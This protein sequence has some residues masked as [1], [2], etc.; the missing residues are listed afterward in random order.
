VKPFTSLKEAKGLSNIRIWM[1]EYQ[2]VLLHG[3]GA[4]T[5]TESD[6]AALVGG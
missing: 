4:H 1:G 6:K 5:G 3:F 2:D